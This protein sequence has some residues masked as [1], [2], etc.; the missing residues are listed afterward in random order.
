MLKIKLCH[1]RNMLNYKYIK[2]ESILI[3]NIISQFQKKQK[4]N[5]GKSYWPQTFEL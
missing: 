5:I 1:D 4:K 2:I 3:C